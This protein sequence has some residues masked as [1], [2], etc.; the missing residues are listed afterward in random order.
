MCG[1]SKLKDES[2]STDHIEHERSAEPF[3]EYT[4]RYMTGRK[5]LLIDQLRRISLGRVSMQNET[6]R[7]LFILLSNRIAV[8][9]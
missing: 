2:Q 9:V 8:A 7:I 5:E 4:L 1:S 6:E 3:D